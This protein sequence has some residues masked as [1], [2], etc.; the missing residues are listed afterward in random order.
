MKILTVCGTRPELIR[1]SLIIKKLDSLVDHTLVFTN[2]NFTHNLSGKFFSEL[3]I[4][5]PN[6]YFNKEATSLGDFLGNAFVEFERI[7][8]RENPDKILVLGDTNSGLLALLANRYGIPIYHMEAG[9]RCLDQ[10]VP[11]ETNRKII[12]LLS[13]YNLP[14]TENSKQNLINEGFD[15]NHI[16]KTGNPLFEVLSNWEKEILSSSITD[17]L[18]IVGKP[19]VLVTVHRAENVDNKDGLESIVK[20]IN[21]ISTTGYTVVISLHPRT[22]DRMLFHGLTFNDKNIVISEPLGLFDYVHLERFADMVI[23]DSGSVP[24]STA[25]FNVPSVIIRESTERQ[26]LIECG[27]SV[28]T[29]TKYSAMVGAFEILRNRK[30]TWR[31]PEDYLVPNVSDIVINILIGK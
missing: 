9:N 8:L 26:E 17:T 24:E 4:R 15:K 29:G 5:K 30:N 1:L 21:Y 2:Q 14:Y 11:E 13:T 3:N 31:V 28:L 20:F 6:Y 7:L 19:Y 22:K 27:A 23:S 10:R 25:I 12:D 16:F 18:D